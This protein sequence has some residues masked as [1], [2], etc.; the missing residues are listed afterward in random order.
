MHQHTAACGYRVLV[1]RIKDLFPFPACMHQAGITQVL[2][3][4]V[5]R[6][7]G[8]RQNVTAGYESLTFRTADFGPGGAPIEFKLLAAPERMPDLE[9]AVEKCKAKLQQYPGVFDVVD[10][11]RLGK[12]EFQLTVKDDAKA[13]GVPLAD[14][15]GTVRAAYYGEAQSP[16]P[17]IVEFDFNFSDPP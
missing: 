14:L 7:T 3:G 15:A 6:A 4:L 9:T 2:E 12:W 11:S 13:M 17:F 10:D 1:E 8:Q 5:Y 16:A